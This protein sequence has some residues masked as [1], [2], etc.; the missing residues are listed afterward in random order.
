MD[1]GGAVLGGEAPVSRNEERRKRVQELVEKIN[2]HP[3]AMLGKKPVRIIDH[4]WALVLKNI[5]DY[6]D[7][8]LPE[9]VELAKMTLYDATSDEYIV[10]VGPIPRR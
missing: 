8:P 6:S 3:L 9:V 1:P 10:V 4:G 5:E 2:A 7:M